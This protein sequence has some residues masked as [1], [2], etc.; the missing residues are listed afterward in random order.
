MQNIGCNMLNLKTE[1]ELIQ[2]LKIVSEEAV[3]E[4]KRRINEEIDPY[5]NSFKRNMENDGLLEQESEEEEEEEEEAE[6]TKDENPPE[7]PESEEKSNPAK[8]KALSLGDYDDGIGSSFESVMT[9]INTLRAGR[10]LKDK[11][12][13]TELNDYYDRLNDNERSILLLFLKELSKILTG[14][15]DGEDAQDPGDPKT[16]FDITKR[17]QEEARDK[18]KNKNTDAEQAEDSAAQS[19][20]QVKQSAPSQGEEDT[21]P[22]IKVN[23][24]QDYSQIRLKIRK[25]MRS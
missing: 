4:S 6:E 15:I 11:E 3:M 1:K 24:S 21:S 20:Q 2:F 23:E 14:A 10:S 18:A 7:E 8:E 13:K 22:P 9:A 19:S 16:Y 12:I 25:L 17:D 5:V